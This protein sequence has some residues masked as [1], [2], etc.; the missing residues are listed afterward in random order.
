MAWKWCIV[1][2]AGGGGSG[3]RY[4][5]N[6]IIVSRKSNL[7]WPRLVLGAYT[8]NSFLVRSVPLLFHFWKVPLKCDLIAST[9]CVWNAFFLVSGRFNL[10]FMADLVW[11]QSIQINESS[12]SISLGNFIVSTGHSNE[13]VCPGLVSGIPSVNARPAVDKNSL[14]IYW[15]CRSSSAEQPKSRPANQRDYIWFMLCKRCCR[16]AKLSTKS[17]KAFPENY[18]KTINYGVCVVVWSLILLID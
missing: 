9:V 4:P 5:R 18:V 15:N 17:T 16:R 10:A 6:F 14:L 7:S 13:C 12:C 1:A 11:L 3:T 8:R 2:R